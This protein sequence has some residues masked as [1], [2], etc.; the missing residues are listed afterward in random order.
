MPLHAYP[1]VFMRG[2]TSRAIHV[3][4]PRIC[5][6]GRLGPI[7]LGAMGSPDP[8]GRQFERHG[9]R[10]IVAVESLYLGTVGTRGR[11]YRLTPSRRCKS[12]NRWWITG[13]TAA[14]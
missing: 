13:A 4:T 9:W 14:T 3:S 11:R 8:N 1:A 5:R 7:F 10:H 12:G 2:G 6:S